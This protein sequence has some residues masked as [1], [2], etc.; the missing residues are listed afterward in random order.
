L[1]KR[2]IRSSTATADS[3][4]RYLDNHDETVI[5]ALITAGAFMALADGRA[6]TIE[7][8]ELVNFVDRQGFVPS[9]SRHEIAEAFNNRVRQLQDRDSAD[10]IA[11]TFR[12]LVG[13]SLAS[14]VVRTATQVAAADRYIDPGELQ[15][16][17]LIRMSLLAADCCCPTS[18]SGRQLPRR[19]SPLLRS[20]G[21]KI[22]GPR[23][24]MTVRIEANRLED[25]Q[26]A[27]NFIPFYALSGTAFGLGPDARTGVV[28]PGATND[29]R[30]R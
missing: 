7:R 14:I 27:F 1:V 6:E 25:G 18:A 5:Q 4:D 20:S 17:K 30:R 19:L 16:L 24:R 2:Y 22:E 3:T 10:V 13:L 23:V 8:D 29:N 15:A 9:A 28:F 26:D 21:P 11:E 12:P